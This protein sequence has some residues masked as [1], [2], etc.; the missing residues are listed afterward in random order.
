MSQT[1]GKALLKELQRH[2]KHAAKLQAEVVK[3]AD[4]ARHTL[5]TRSGTEAANSSKPLELKPYVPKAIDMSTVAKFKLEELRSQ[6]AEEI[7]QFLKHQR[8]YKELLERYSSGPVDTLERVNATAKRVGLD[9]SK[10]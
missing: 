7:L 5:A 1:V 2:G 3:K 6:D 10:L 4:F 8:E 9:A